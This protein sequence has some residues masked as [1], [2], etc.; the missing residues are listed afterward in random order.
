MTLKWKLYWL[1]VA[2]MLANY[3]A[4]VVWSLP[5]LQDM[6]GGLPAF[7]LRPGGYTFDEALAFVSAIGAHGR[8]FYLGT[9]QWLDTLYPALLGGVLVIALLALAPARVRL[10]LAAFATAGTVFDYLENHAVAAMLKAGPDGLTEGMADAASRWTVLK[11]AT[12][13]LA[14]TGLAILLV[15]RALAWWQNRRKANG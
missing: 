4:M 14:M 9:Q 3:V 11:S 13:A 10:L 12:S 8:A 5:A 15:F 7:D 2:V 1:L 6:A